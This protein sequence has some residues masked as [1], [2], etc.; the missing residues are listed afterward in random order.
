MK[1]IALSLCLLVILALCG[2][3][4]P[5]VKTAEVDNLSNA[6]LAFTKNMGQ[7]PDSILFRADAGGAVMWFVQDGIYYQFS[8]RIP[9]PQ[10]GEEA[11]AVGLGPRQIDPADRLHQEPD[12]IETT[13]I[14]AQFVGASKSVELIGL[15]ELDYKCNYFIGNDPAKWHT[16]V[17]NYT[18][19]TFKELY[20]GVDAAFA[21]REGR[22][23]CQLTA[24]SPADLAQVK[25]EYLGAGT[26]TQE[27]ENI[28]AIQT[29]FGE[30]RF[31]GILPV[32]SA[33]QTRVKTTS[34]ESSSAGVSLVY[35]TYLGGSNNDAGDA[36]AV[37][38]SGNAFVTGATN[39]TTFPPQN[40]YDAS[41]NGYYEA[42]VTKLSPA[43]NSLVYSTYLGGSSYDYGLGI[44]VDG[45]GSAYV[46]GY[47]GSSDF[48]TQNF[49]DAS[50]N[51]SY[52]VFVT[53]LSATGN[54]LLYST[55]LGGSNFD[56]GAVVAVDGSGS[57]Y[58]TGGTE[59]TNF[60]TQ[61][62]YNASQNGQRD[63]FVTKLSTTGNSLLYSTYLG[64]SNYD[65]GLGLAV[66]GGGNAYVTGVTNS[67]NFPTQSPYDA[68]HNG[69][70]DA[71][72]T[73]LSA[74]G[75]SLVYST[76]L[77][78]SDFEHGW[79]IAVD[80]SGNAYVTG[81]TGSPNFPT[82]D[83]YD[84]SHNDSGDVFVT[85]LSATGNNLLYSTY[86][87]GSRSDNGAGIALDGSGNAYVT[88]ATTSPDFPTQNPYDA[89]HHGIWYDV[90]VT[91]LSATGNSLLYSTYLG[92]YDYDHGW[93]IAVDGSGSAYV[94]GA[95]YSP[96]F[97]TQNSYD[98]SYNGNGDA[99]VTKLSPATT[100]CVGMTGNV[101]GDANDIVD[102]SD[103]S[104]M[105]DYL[106]FGGAISGCFEEND[107]DGSASVD[108]S[109]LSILVDFLFF[110]GS[111][112][113]C[114]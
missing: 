61:N 64:G 36:I 2:A 82:Q 48:P 46:T 91:K 71:F 112:P 83:P 104:A 98:A 74:T 34:K 28:V 54:S 105:V 1:L 25:T 85:K 53:K 21:E 43:G 24:A 15:E 92:E 66:D 17:P 55:Y 22:L 60:P 78:G 89:S 16:D 52:D 111:L 49:Y 44:A 23:E 72:V 40:A 35:S 70:N 33:D 75:N 106:F 62:P 59:S 84:A 86:L 76:Y 99:F 113:S 73:K 37:D 103:L 50:Y 12:S 107:V 58:V 13:M 88:G 114:P 11:L 32:E 81:E 51:G 19:I 102:I 47:T 41:H 4:D 97:P 67:T 80:G 69:L 30:K 57:A 8:K 93:D 68:S 79:D 27:S 14:K 7:W 38:G 109:D 31:A 18:G 96:T 56:G 39:S 110:G 10:S 42:F 65:D 94:T 108:I 87:G 63:G 29:I 20:P 101:D 3:A 77:G 95:T 26:V 6:P 90:F 100:C 9:R 5:T 45:S